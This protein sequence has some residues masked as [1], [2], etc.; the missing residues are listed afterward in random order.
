MNIVNYSDCYYRDA[1]YLENAQAIMQCH[2]PNHVAIDGFLSAGDLE[3]LRNYI[4]SQAD[5]FEVSRLV[6]GS[7]NHQL[8]RSK[9]LYSLGD[10]RAGFVDKLRMTIPSAAKELG[11][12]S[13]PAVSL[14]LQATSTN[15][16]EFF[17]P[18]IDNRHKSAARRWLSFTFFLHREPRKFSGG[19]LRIAAGSQKMH[20]PRTG[21]SSITPRCNRIV[22]FPSGLLHEITPVDCSSGAL[23]DSRLTV[24]G[25]VLR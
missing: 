12:R 11:F 19:E 14:Q 21:C 18:H 9:V 15:D 6:N 4:Y 8:R 17:R 7:V 22:F 24:N 3:E 1:G 2:H 20:G 5:D 13:V 10:P 23:E 25:W 16:G